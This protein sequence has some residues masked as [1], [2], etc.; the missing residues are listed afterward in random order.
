M[1][2]VRWLHHC[3]MAF[4]ALA[5]LA[6]LGLI[7]ALL[8]LNQR[9]FEGEWG[10][11]IARELDRRGIHADFRQ[12]RF[13]PLRGILARDVVVYFSA[14]RQRILAR[15]PELEIEVDR[16]DALKGDLS[17]RSLF[18]KDAR[19]A[20]PV[21]SDPRHVVRFGNL[22]GRATLDRQS[23]LVLDEATGRLAG[24]DF[25]LSVE[26]DAFDPARLADRTPAAPPTRTHA[27]VSSAFA[28]CDRWSFPASRPPSL[29]IRIAGSLE[30]PSAIRTSVSINARELSRRSYEMENLRFKGEISGRSLTV[31]HLSF[32]DGPG[33]LNLRADFD[34]LDQKGRYELS[35]SVDLPALLRRG[36]DLHTLDDLVSARAPRLEATG[37]FALPD[38]DLRLGAIGS[39][40]LPAFRF[41]GQ[42]FESLTTEF[43][44]QD[45]DLFLR[46]LHVGHARGEFTGKILLKGDSIRYRATSSL[47]VSVYTPFVGQGTALDQ[48][49]SQCRFSGRSQVVIE[50]DG[51][52]RRSDLKEWTSRG[53]ASVKHI[54]FSGVPLK[55]A[56]AKFHI[57]PIESTFSNASVAFDYSSYPPRQQHHGPESSLV[58]ADEFHYRKETNLTRI[59]NLRGSAWPGPL[60]KLFAPRTASYVERTYRSRLPVRFTTNGIADH[61]EPRH[62]TDLRTD[63]HAPG[64]TDYDFL[65]K[66]LQL[67]DVS[68]R[69]RSRHELVNVTGLRF[70]S[71][72]GAGGGNLTVRLPSGQPA[73]FSG[74]MKWNDLSLAAI[75]RK[76]GFE[77]AEKGTLR[78]RFDFT[79]V[80]NNT[81]TLNGRGVIALRNGQ[82]FHVPV[83]G[84]L[85][86]PIEGVLGNKRFSHEEARDASATFVM[87]EGV[88]YTNDFLTSTPST[89]FTGEGWVDIHAKTIDL[90]LRM[91]ARGLLGLVTLPL[92]PFSGLFQFRGRG[93]LRNPAW[94]SAP[95][96]Q[97]SRGRSDPVFRKPPRARIVPDTARPA[98][99][100]ADR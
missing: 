65:G 99:Q 49:I 29:D 45:G 63:L 39:V 95:F 54:R 27:L 58:K 96:T 32:S 68:L 73:S 69:L 31:D 78:G 5:S 94:R 15:I 12:V 79:G 88:A 11:R 56:A 92:R 80:R 67:E 24:M 72:L 87:K 42:P 9:G 46:D 35:S 3:K 82:L 40:S 66:T 62:R 89:V 22:T 8:W 51:S 1:L 71:F 53:N 20:I 13:S 23:R 98:P 91:N 6:A 86:A 33:S 76:Y 10:E 14:S 75:G 26:L 47:P 83:F 61:R 19:L 59:S 34:L 2:R 41:L 38:G 4:F 44:W 81:R 48:T 43:S 100:P 7:G 55:Q 30:R 74:G 97:P 50:A 57:T 60:L 77:T 18:L 90:T 17:L 70:R 28:E 93:P 16:T 85:S 21:G 36:F 52:I 37:K 25:R 64:I 84:P